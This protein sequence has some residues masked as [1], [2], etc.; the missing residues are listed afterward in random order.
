MFICLPSSPPTHILQFFHEW[1]LNE[2][3]EYSLFSPWHLF[4][5]VKWN[6][7]LQVVNNLKSLE[8]ID[9]SWVPLLANKSLALNAGWYKIN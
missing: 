8:L 4:V 9:T 7:L 6:E 3:V 2:F 1:N 5:F